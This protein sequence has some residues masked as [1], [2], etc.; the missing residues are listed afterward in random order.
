[1]KK[2]LTDYNN[3]LINA[4][5]SLNVDELENIAEVIIKARSDSNVVYLIGNGSVCHLE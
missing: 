5:H 2:F 3:D 4:I 1:M